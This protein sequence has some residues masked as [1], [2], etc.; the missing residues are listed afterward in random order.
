MISIG[1]EVGGISNECPTSDAINGV[2]N[3]RAGGK[4]D[5]GVDN[6]NSDVPGLNRCSCDLIRV[7]GVQWR[8]K[9][10]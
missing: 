7:S 9:C 10:N 4:R 3:V 6:V 5:S 8:V 2:A 1:I